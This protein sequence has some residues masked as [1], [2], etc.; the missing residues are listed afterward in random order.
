MS[1]I[2]QSA[3]DTR[4][5]LQRLDNLQGFSVQDLLKEAERIFN[6][7]ET[8]EEGEDRVRRERDERDKKRNRGLRKLLVTAMQKNE[9]KGNRGDEKIRPK[10]DKDQCAYCKKKGHWARECP[11]KKPREPRKQRPQISLLALDED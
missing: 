5:K 3:P 1:F 9:R 4:V 10:L 6:K 7:G 8:P 2:W 11:N